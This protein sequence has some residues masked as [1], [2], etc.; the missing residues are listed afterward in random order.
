MN[1]KEQ[2]QQQQATSV[3]YRRHTNFAVGP[4]N[5]STAVLEALS[6]LKGMGKKI[7]SS[8]L[9]EAKWLSGNQSEYTILNKN[10]DGKY[11]IEKTTHKENELEQ[12]ADL[13][14]GVE[15]LTN[16][17]DFDSEETAKF[18]E[19]FVIY[20]N[21]GQEYKAMIIKRKAHSVIV[22]SKI[23]PEEV[24]EEEE[25]REPL[26]ALE[27]SEVNYKILPVDLMI[28][29]VV[30]K[31]S[32]S[33]RTKAGKA[34]FDL[35]R[36]MALIRIC[37]IVESIAQEKEQSIKIEGRLVVY[38]PKTEVWIPG[39]GGNRYDEA[40]DPL[41][42]E[43]LNDLKRSLR[44]QSFLTYPFRKRPF[45]AVEIKD[46]KENVVKMR[47]LA[48]EYE[49]FYDN[50]DYPGVRN[51][52]LGQNASGVR[53]PG[54]P[55]SYGLALPLIALQYHEVRFAGRIINHLDAIS[56]KIEEVKVNENEK[57]REIYEQ[58][59]KFDQLIAALKIHLQGKIG[60][61][62][63]EFLVWFEKAMALEEKKENGEVHVN[64][65]RS[66]TTVEYR[67]ALGADLKKLKGISSSVE[68]VRAQ[69]CLA[70]AAAY[71]NVVAVDRHV[72][73]AVIEG[74]IDKGKHVFMVKV[75]EGTKLPMYFADSAWPN[76][77]ILPPGL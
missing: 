55:A 25:V 74:E 23:V 66:E 44:R 33:K 76:T 43:K 65:P 39:E 4:K 48:K 18:A 69:N 3:V 2:Q 58:R 62:Q 52:D 1:H 20:S 30:V 53:D 46:L 6:T 15:K 61:L 5:A 27:I 7:L 37:H 11:F 31:P 21:K 38:N 26:D 24:Q 75:K 56:A 34:R 45:V 29:N 12:K 9:K 73:Y 17:L 22:E 41:V 47:E 28:K 72:N 54:V 10:I 77:F 64:A 19:P 42:A 63:A 70:G 51:F 68:M 14:R 8:H 13:L 36:A 71:S 32:G 16:K 49:Q 35:G 59:I 57:A 40:V 67:E 60:Q 50:T